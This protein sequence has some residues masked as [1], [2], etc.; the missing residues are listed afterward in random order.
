VSGGGAGLLHAAHSAPTNA[1][2]KAIVLVL[3]VFGAITDAE[4]Q[5]IAARRRVGDAAED[6]GSR[7]LLRWASAY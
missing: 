1:G 4:P 5:T 3:I 2:S 7:D 6:V